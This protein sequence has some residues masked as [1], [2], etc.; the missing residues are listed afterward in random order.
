MSYYVK[1]LLIP[2]LSVLACSCVP[3][4]SP[5]VMKELT[6]RLFPEHADEFRFGFIE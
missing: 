2:I 4:N 1:L 6:E 5:A 3:D